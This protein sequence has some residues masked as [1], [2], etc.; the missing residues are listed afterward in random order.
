MALTVKL[1]AFEGPLDLLFHLIEKNKIDIYDIPIAELTEQYLIYLEELTVN[2]IDIASE[3]LLMAATLLKIKSKMLLPETQQS[4]V[5]ADLEAATED[6]DPRADL[7]ERLIEYK[8]FKEIAAILSSKEL[9]QRKI[10]KKAP[11][12][13]TF[14]LPED[15][16]TLSQVTFKD[17]VKAFN[18][19]M[20]EKSKEKNFHVIPKEP[21]PLNL[22]IRQVYNLVDRNKKGVLFS[23]LFEN[24][25]SKEELIVTFLAV[26][27][28]VKMNKI[29]AFQTN[30]F[31]DIMLVQKGVSY[32]V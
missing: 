13:L 6:T 16:F 27:E 20:K 8:K 30:L 28:L 23:K 15:E 1:E 2:D 17:L 32:G 21:I 11:E 19:L 26:L 22:R 24:D 10:L 18:K 25:Y 4:E 7:V 14:L 5:D 31:S 12:D 3:F 29:N 9:E